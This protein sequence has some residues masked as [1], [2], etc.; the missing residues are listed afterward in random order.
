MID[1]QYV[2]NNVSNIEKLPNVTILK[3]LMQFKEQL[4]TSGA[5]HSITIGEVTTLEAEENAYVENVGTSTDLILN[6][7]IPKGVGFNFS[8]EW[9]GGNNEYH[10]ND[11]VLFNGNLYIC[12]SS[13]L[14]SETPPNIDTPHW[15][16][17]V[18]YGNAISEFVKNEYEKSLN[19]IIFNEL[20]NWGIS[21]GSVYFDYDNKTITLTNGTNQQYVEILKNLQLKPNTTYTYNV[22]ANGAYRLYAY[23]NNAY[24]NADNTHLSFTTGDTGIVDRL[25]VDNLV[26]ADPFVISE[27]RLYEGSEDLGYKVGY[28]DILHKADITPKPLWENAVITS[29]F[30]GQTLN[31][32]ISGKTKY[33]GVDCV[34]FKSNNAIV[35]QFVFENRVG[36]A[37]YILMSSSSGTFTRPITFEGDGSIVF[38]DCSKNNEHCIPVRIYEFD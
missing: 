12:I 36:G 32:K 38:G 3:M 27:V 35:E 21:Q 24:P 11:V 26:G 17:F 10:P 9:V 33:V 34:Y 29:D 28:G 30:A 23:V 14:D 6:F 7:G 2:I 16:L 13:I 1:K 19:K 20:K 4:E 22:K 31:A 8:D 15:S 37:G 18:G 25:R 5:Y